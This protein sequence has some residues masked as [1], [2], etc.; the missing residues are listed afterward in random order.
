MISNIPECYCHSSLE[1]TGLGGYYM[2]G[3]FIS[4]LRYFFGE[5]GQ[6]LYPELRDRIW[7]P[8]IKD[9]RILIESVSFWKPQDLQRRPA[10]MVKRGQ[11]NLLKKT[12]GEGQVQSILSTLDTFQEFWEG[13]HTVFA[14]GRSEG[15]A[16]LLA[17]EVGLAISQFSPKLRPDFKLLRLRLLQYGDVSQLEEDR[18][19]Y[20]VPLTFSYGYVRFW[21]LQSESPAMKTLQL[22][23]DSEIDS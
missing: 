5:A 9:T 23:T 6:I 18:Q 1:T 2:T 21:T 13:S 22:G 11:Q 16:E 19:Y 15:E 3:I 8:D 12:I 4:L 14:L 7:K 20:V 17:D 10:L